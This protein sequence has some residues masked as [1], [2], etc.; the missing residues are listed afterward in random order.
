MNDSEP[1][2]EVSTIP[3]VREQAALLE[4]AHDAIIVRDPGSRIRY[5]NKGAEQTYGWT[6]EEALGKVTHT[7]LETQFSCI[8]SRRR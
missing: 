3:S 6:R 5:W 2:D 8:R 7:F 4:I 1:T